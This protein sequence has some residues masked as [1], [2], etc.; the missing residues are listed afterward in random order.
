MEARG[1]GN[2]VISIKGC[3]TFYSY[4]SAEQTPLVHFH[5]DYP[6]LMKELCLEPIVASVG[7]GG[8]VGGGAS[9]FFDD[10]DDEDQ[11]SEDESES[12]E[13]DVME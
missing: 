5:A 13:D 1:A 2:L 4:D 10:D 9:A 8:A 7:A 3:S 11:S 6:D 12:G